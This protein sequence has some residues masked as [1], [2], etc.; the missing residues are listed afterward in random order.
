MTGTRTRDDGAARTGRI[1]RRI[2]LHA[3]RVLPV[4]PVTV[5]NEERNRAADRFAVADAGNDVGG[6]ALD[7]HALTAAVAELTAAEIAGEIRRRDA[8]SGRHAF[9]DHDQRAAVR[10][11]CSEKTKHWLGILSKFLQ[12]HRRRAAD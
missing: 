2:G 3:H 10:F 8:Q 11:T 5:L 7:G 12:H 6:I 1:C 9:D 4:R